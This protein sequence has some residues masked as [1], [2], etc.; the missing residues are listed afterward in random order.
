MSNEIKSTRDYDK[1]KLLSCNRYQNKEELKSSPEFKRLKQSISQ[2]NQ[3][4]AFP[5]LVNGRGEVIDGQHRL[6]A[7]KDLGM[8]IYY[9]EDKNINTNVMQLTNTAVKKWGLIDHINF[10]AD[11]YKN[12]EYIN[13]LKLMKSSKMSSKALLLLLAGDSKTIYE[14]IKNGKFMMPKKK[15]IEEV[16]ESYQGFIAYCEDKHITPMSMFKCNKFVKA[17]NWLVSTSGYKEK[18]LYSSLDSKWFDLK[19]QGDA[20]AWYELLIGIYNYR[21]QKSKLEVEYGRNAST[22]E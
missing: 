14:V 18:I 6:L 21:Q 8:P 5:I 1:F 10:F 16:I 4:H 15:N 2:D 9:I 3:L 11:H 19:P 13:L 12:E 17:F 7:A 22:E 20:T